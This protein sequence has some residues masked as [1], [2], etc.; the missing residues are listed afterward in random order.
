[1]PNLQPQSLTS[2]L[3]QR[4]SKFEFGDVPSEFEVKLFFREAEKLK[5]VDLSEGWMVAGIIDTLVY[6]YEDAKKAFEKSLSNGPSDLD[7]VVSN[8]ALALLRLGRFEEAIEL[9][10]KYVSDD[11]FILLNDAFSL[12]LKTGLF[13]AATFYS[14]KLKKFSKPENHDTKHLNDLKTACDELNISEPDCSAIHLL[15]LNAIHD[16]KIP[17]VDFAVRRNDENDNSLILLFYVDA[18]VDTLADIGLAIID[19]LVESDITAIVEQKVTPLVM[20][21]FN[22]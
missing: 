8:Y 2:E 16:K 20:K 13:N 7:I 18:D 4:L 14:E 3:L 5:K 15:V 21:G 9:V 17:A 11:N 1:M 12:T 19:K 22:Q 6:N 10:K